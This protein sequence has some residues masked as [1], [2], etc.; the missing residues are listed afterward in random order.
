MLFLIVGSK[1][2]PLRT[3]R[4]VLGGDD[5]QAPTGYTK[6]FAVIEIAKDGS[7]SISAT[8]KDVAVRVNGASLGEERVTLTHGARID[9]AGRKLL[10]AD[11]RGVA[12][13]PI[14]VSDTSAALSAADGKRYPIAATG[15]DIGRDPNCDVVIA[16]DDVSRW[17]AYIA[18]GPGGYQLKDS[19][20]NGVY[21]NGERVRGER[22][23]RTGDKIRVGAAQFRFDSGAATSDDHVTTMDT[24]Q[25]TRIAQ[26]TARPRAETPLP[27][28]TVRLSRPGEPA[29]PEPPLLATLE[30]VTNGALKGKR[31]RITRPLVHVGRSRNND[32][33][34][35]NQSVSSAHAKLQQRG[36]DWFLADGDSK[37]GTFVD[38]TRVS[39][40]RKLPAACEIRFG[41][42]TALFRALAGGQKEGPS[43]QGVVGIMDA[44][45][46]KKRRG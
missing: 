42:V 44:Q 16:S 32:V 22:W 5:A 37:N 40:E 15:L 25:L 6:S 24:D 31:F 13:T 8:G 10:F 17:H 28:E 1:R 46:D 29:T 43:T 34:L 27:T 9:I 14:P 20:A 38:G 36:N 19:S 23:L 26:R 39:G 7:A 2:L 11:E 41:V 35:P 3:G 4:N 12:A 18:A 21:V 45:I 33:V 30:L